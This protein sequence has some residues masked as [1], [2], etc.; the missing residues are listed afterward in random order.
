MLADVDAIALFVSSIPGCSGVE[1]NAGLRIGG[2]LVSKG[3]LLRFVDGTV[4]FAMSCH[5]V[6]S[7]FYV[8]QMVA[9]VGKH[10]YC[11]TVVVEE[12]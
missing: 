3:D 12:S 10:R 2:L 8:N 5:K 4:G 7:N 9:A 11:N 1:S 6:G